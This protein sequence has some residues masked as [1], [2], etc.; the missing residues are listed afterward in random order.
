MSSSFGIRHAK[1]QIP[2]ERTFNWRNSN[3]KKNNLA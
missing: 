1:V 3:L 2:L